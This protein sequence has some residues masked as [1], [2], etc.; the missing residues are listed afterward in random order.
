MNGKKDYL[1]DTN[2]LTYFLAGKLPENAIGKI[3]DNLNYSFNISVITKL[4]ILGW[5]GHTEKTFRETE[6]FIRNAVIIGLE[7]RV[8]DEAIN[9]RRQRKIKL[10]DAVIAATARVY[11][12][13]LITNNEGDFKDL[14]K[15]WNPLKE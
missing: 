14:V 6:S 1:F 13:T 9:L 5:K 3:E 7:D 11:N 12:K 4:E 15:V 10:P 2:I 8:V